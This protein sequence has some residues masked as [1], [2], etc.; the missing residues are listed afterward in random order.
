MKLPGTHPCYFKAVSCITST[1]WSNK[2][3]GHKNWRA[4]LQNFEAFLPKKIAHCIDHDLIFIMSMNRIS[5]NHLWRT[6]VRMFC[7]ESRATCRQA[8][9]LRYH[10]NVLG[11]AKGTVCCLFG[12]EPCVL[13]SL[14]WHV[15]TWKQMCSS[16]PRCVHLSISRK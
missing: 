7:C 11:E 8:M 15:T 14:S 3:Q 13:P 6:R 9:G 16:P 5:E 2:I 1:T 12:F 10:G 4:L